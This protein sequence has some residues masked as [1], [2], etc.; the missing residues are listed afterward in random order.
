MKVLIFGKR[1]KSDFGQ[2][3]ETLRA[4]ITQ[5]N[6]DARFY[7]EFA[8]Q[9]PDF[10][11]DVISNHEELKAFNPEAVITIGGDG[12][13]LSAAVLIKELEIPILG[14]NMGRLGFL[15]SIEQER[16]GQALDLLVNGKYRISERTMLSLQS[17]EELYGEENF[18]LNDFTLVKRDDSSMIVIH[19]YINGEFLISYWADGLIVSTPTGSTAYSLSCG[20]P[21]TFPTADNFILTPVA[22]HNLNVRPVVIPGDRE[23]SFQIEG[24]SETFLCTLD[25]RNKVI[26]SN[27]EISLKKNDFLSKFIILEGDNFMQTIRHKLN[28]GL[29]RRN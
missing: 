3:L 26:T 2:H 11:G 19:T 20:G 5:Y 23:I 28:W 29:D 22:P 27:T 8:E 13:I 24:R 1:W 25:G 17:N 21:I 9:I 6:I 14:I 12:T 16:L 10:Q 4:K 15:A 18:A 7:S